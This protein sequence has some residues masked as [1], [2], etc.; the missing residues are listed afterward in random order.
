MQP[1]HVQLDG[2]HDITRIQI[3]P[4]AVISGVY[5]SEPPENYATLNY[6]VR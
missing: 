6:K 3:I 2:A 5:P 4:W 1:A